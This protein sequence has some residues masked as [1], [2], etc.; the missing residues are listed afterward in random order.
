MAR[1]TWLALESEAT[2][3]VQTDENIDPSV[4]TSGD[5]L[6]VPVVV[7]SP[8]PVEVSQNP[9]QAELN[10]DAVY[11]ESE[12]LLDQGEDLVS[13]INE[14]DEVQS[15]IEVHDELNS[16]AAESYTRRVNAIC[17]RWGIGGIKKPAV[18]NYDS[19]DGQRLARRVA[20]EG[21]ASKAMEL[22]KRFIDWIMEL[23]ANAKEAWVSYTN[24]GSAIVKRSEVLRGQIAK[25][26][27]KTL[28]AEKIDVTEIRGLQVAGKWALDAIVSSKGDILNSVV[29]A[30]KDI[31]LRINS[32]GILT[33]EGKEVPGMTQSFSSR[34]K[35]VSDMI[36]QMV[37][38]NEGHL[39]QSRVYP[40][41]GNTALFALPI[42]VAAHVPT[43][44]EENLKKQLQWRYLKLNVKVDPIKIDP[45]YPQGLKEAVDAMEDI[46]NTLKGR[47]NDFKAKNEQLGRLKDTLKKAL[48]KAEADRKVLAKTVESDL[49]GRE[50]GTV[51][52]LTSRAMVSI[53]RSSI[54]SFKAMESAA[55][56]TLRLT[57]DGLNKV[58]SLSLKSYGSNAPIDSE[59][60]KTGTASNSSRGL[61]TV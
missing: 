10:S 45:L 27:S 9:D 25:V 48:E 5:E 50:T 11:N 58:I 13:D 40:L 30:S 34:V 6:E 12:N 2:Q 17:R 39:D 46:G 56:N 36:E 59:A 28:N 16:V 19:V 23:I 21:I 43:Y 54:S 31:D 53:A 18:E 15:N 42:Q 20:C 52:V 51:N 33:F 35:I 7:T 41:V 3:N 1:R 37:Q 24:Q 22:G 32:D 57:G 29:R 61:A 47:I 38:L 60:A 44:L 55:V 8:G 14:V 4:A 49:K 26:D